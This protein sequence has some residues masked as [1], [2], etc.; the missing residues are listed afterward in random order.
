MLSWTESSCFWII[1]IQDLLCSKL[2]EDSTLITLC[3]GFPAGSVIGQD[4]YLV[5]S[6][7]AAEEVNIDDRFRYIDDL[8]ILE[9]IM[10]SGILQEYD[11]FSHVPS[12]LPQDYKYL[13]GNTTQ[14][15]ANL[16]FISRWTDSNKM[17]LNPKKCFLAVWSS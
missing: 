5:A 6:N 17:K 7:D 13:A 12:D 2:G 16:N 10:L 15:Q 14:T 9:L 1:I 11:G 4:C 8:E 3:G